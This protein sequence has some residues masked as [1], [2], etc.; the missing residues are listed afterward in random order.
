MTEIS[1]PA[2]Q[3]RLEWLTKA[4]YAVDPEGEF[5]LRY[6]TKE[7]SS[8]RWELHVQ[9]VDIQY[10]TMHPT[11]ADAIMELEMRLVQEIKELKQRHTGKL[12][13]L[14]TLLPR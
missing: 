1:Y 7:L 9:R 8:N 3:E 5:T 2:I 14:T 10:R 4:L 12:E 6:R 13:E 11:L